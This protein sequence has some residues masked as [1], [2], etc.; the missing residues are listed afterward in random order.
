LRNAE[1]VPEIDF[2][3]MQFET[4]TGQ[5]ARTFEIASLNSFLDFRE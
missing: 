2:F 5:F 4:G 3:G 1:Q